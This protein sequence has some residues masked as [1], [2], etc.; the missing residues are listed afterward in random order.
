MKILRLMLFT[1]FVLFLSVSAS[2]A[3]INLVD[4]ETTGFRSNIDNNVTQVEVS[5]GSGNAGDLEVLFCSTVSYGGNSFLD[6]AP[7]GWMEIN[8]GECGGNGPCIFGIFRRFDQSA[9]SSVIACNWTDPTS[10]VAAISFRYSGVDSENPVIDVQC[11]EGTGADQLIIPSVNTEPGSAVI[12]AISFGFAPDQNMMINLQANPI[13]Q[14][15]ESAVGQS[16][17]PPIQQVI[18]S[19]QSNLYL[20]G[21]PTGDFQFGTAGS[22]WRGC[23]IALRA[24]PTTIPTLSEWGMIAAATGLM[25]V[26]VYF[27]VRRRKA[28]AV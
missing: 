5:S 16:T 15:N 23:A 17:S 18:V 27:A 12:I 22:D 11:S 10:A 2:R 3:R 24:V 4:S 6:P 25:I 13:F 20:A 28:Q 1:F 26:G 14:G 19:A 21:G 8:Q 9:D 7:D